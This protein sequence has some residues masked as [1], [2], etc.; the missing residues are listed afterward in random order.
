MD[1]LKTYPPYKNALEEIIKETLEFGYGKLFT[2]QSLS[3]MM[4]MTQPKTIPEYKKFEFAYMSAIENLKD[5]LL[6]EHHM[7]LC[8]EKGQ[9]YRVLEPE[10]Q[11]STGADR[12]FKK[13]F[14]E[15]GK[16]MKSLVYVQEEMLS[17]QAKLDRQRKMQ[18]AAFIQASYRKK[19]LTEVKNIAN[20]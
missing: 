3:D 8:N 9:G 18:R 5:E 2:H 10:E 1:D 15:I 20:G 16:A 19:K 17:D 12:F 13:S 4:D 14:R 11:V 6:I 7:F